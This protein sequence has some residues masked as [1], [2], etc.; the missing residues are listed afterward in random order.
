MEEKIFVFKTDIQHPSEAESIK[1]LDEVENISDW[2]TDLEDCDNILRVVG[3]GIR[4][5]QIIQMINALGFHC[6][7]LACGRLT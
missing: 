2:S 4:S 1:I 5:G 6:E 7:E 3:R